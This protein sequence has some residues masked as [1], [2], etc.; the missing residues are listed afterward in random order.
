V[1][2]T[3]QP[4][5]VELP[6]TILLTI[7]LFSRHSSLLRYYAAR[8]VRA[9]RRAERAL[10]GA[11]PRWLPPQPLWLRPYP[12]YGADTLDAVVAAAE[13]EGLSH[14]VLMF[15]SSELMPGGSP[16]RPTPASVAQLL[17]LLDDFFARL[18]RAGHTFATLT[19]AGRELAVTPHL[20]SFHLPA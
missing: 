9:L 4:G 18:R 16:Y 1:S 17:G 3:G 6:L 2:G 7:G 15:H 20:R 13:R 14:A 10:R 8:P 12:E 5:L 11:Q 19:A